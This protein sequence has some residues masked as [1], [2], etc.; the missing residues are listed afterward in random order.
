M[1]FNRIEILKEWKQ[2]SRVDIEFH[3]RLTV[4]TG[5]N[6]S[7]KTTLLNILSLHFGWPSQELSTPAK[8]KKTGL[9][10]FFPWFWKKPAQRTG[11]EMGRLTYSSGATA[12]LDI[13]DQDS[14]VFPINIVNR[15][16]IKGLYVPSHRPFF[17]Y[18]AIEQLPTKKRRKTEAFTLVADSLRQRALGGG[19][20]P[21]NYYIKE[22]LL[23]WA[24]YGEG[25]KYIETDKEQVSNYEGFE[26][27]LRKVLP[28]QLGFKK[29][30]PRPPEIV[31]D[32][33]TGQYM[34][35]AVSGGVSAIMDLA[36][37]IFM[38]STKE[39]E[40][41]TVLVDEI[42][43]H[44]HATM[45]R[46]ILPDFLEAFPSVQFIVSTHN[47]LIVGSV[48][49]SKVYV[50]QFQNDKKVTSRELDLVNKAKTATE[51]LREV[52]GV[53]FTMPIWVEDQLHQIIDKYSKL[54]VDERMLKKMRRELSELG[55]ENLVPQ[56]L[57]GVLD[58]NK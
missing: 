16:D 28:E 48:K 24:L 27:V 45:Q 55:L 42:E 25:N 31:L 19:G 14:A 57:T 33:E 20:Q 15:Q 52:L 32:T 18:T 30:I 58:K 22:S 34:I 4:L 8:D 17:S 41:L 43:N 51:I 36:W 21:T 54:K 53:P 44:L 2:F 7:G 9:F 13:P 6:G 39:G 38:A 23:T 26:E 46:S 12:N 37:Q 3:P 11:S 47:P 56:A 10:R 50:L 35:D 1:G 40:Q 29:L 49:D 5:A